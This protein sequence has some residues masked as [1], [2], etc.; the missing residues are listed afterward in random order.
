MRQVMA[1]AEACPLAGM[2]SIMRDLH[3]DL[4]PRLLRQSAREQRVIESAEVLQLMVAQPL[5][6]RCWPEPDC[7]ERR[8]GWVHLLCLHV[9][10]FIA[11]SRLRCC[12]ELLMILTTLVRHGQ[13]SL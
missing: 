11:C 8:A 6:A 5:A 4:V 7:P 12:D 13:M 1:T 2:V 3:L 10:S 9:Q